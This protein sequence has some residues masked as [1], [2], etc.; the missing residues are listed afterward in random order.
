MT[1][2]GEKYVPGQSV[3]RRLLNEQ[4]DQNVVYDDDFIQLE[5]KPPFSQETAFEDELLI[6]GGGF[7]NKIISKSHNYTQDYFELR[8]QAA[9]SVYSGGGLDPS[10]DYDRYEPHPGTILF[11]RSLSG[12]VTDITILTP[13]G[14]KTRTFTRAN[15]V[16]TSIDIDNY[17]TKRNVAFSRTEGKVELITI[18]DTT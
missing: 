11:T 7:N 3:D 8:A 17:G 12:E 14:T 4:F 2:F 6:I 1:K 15:G 13:M 5:E 9:P 16:V 10:L 18:T